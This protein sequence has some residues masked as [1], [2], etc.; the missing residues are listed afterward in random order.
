MDEH[1]YI[2]LLIIDRRL[3]IFT[4]LF[5]KFLHDCTYWSIHIKTEMKFK[6]FYIFV[7]KTESNNHFF[8]Y[9]KSGRKMENKSFSNR[10]Y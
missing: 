9:H 5:L 3:I 8:A 10:I 7:H 2:G 6:S 1:C 4:K